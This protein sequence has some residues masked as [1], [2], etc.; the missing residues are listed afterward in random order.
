MSS[1]DNA[2]KIAE[3]PIHIM[4]RPGAGTHPD[5]RTNQAVDLIL[6]NPTLS[7]PQAMLAVGFSREESADRAKQMWIR[8]R[9][10]SKKFRIAVKANSAELQLRPTAAAALQ[11]KPSA[12]MAASSLQQQ[13]TNDEELMGT[14]NAGG[15][16]FECKL[17][18][19]LSINRNI[20][21]GEGAKRMDMRKM[22]L[23]QCVQILSSLA[24]KIICGC[25]GSSGCGVG[26]MPFIH[27]DFITIDNVI[28]CEPTT[29][30]TSPD[31]RE[32]YLS[33]YFI[34]CSLDRQCL[35]KSNENEAMYAFARIAFALCTMGDEPE[36]PDHSLNS[37]TADGTDEELVLN[38]NMRKE[39]SE[40]SYVQYIS[41]MMCEAGVP[42]PM[43]QFISDL[44]NGSFNHFEEVHSHLNQMIEHPDRFLFGETFDV[45]G[46]R[47]DPVVTEREVGD[48]SNAYSCIV[49]PSLP[50]GHPDP[51]TKQ[52]VA[53]MLKNPKQTVPQAM[54]AAGF[55]EEESLDRTKQMW[56]RRRIPAKKFMKEGQTKSTPTT[57]ASAP[58]PAALQMKPSPAAALQMKV[59]PE[60]ASTDEV[61]LCGG[62]AGE[63]PFECKLQ[64]W[65]SIN[66]NNFSGTPGQEGA[67]PMD[68]SKRKIYLEQCVQILHS[69][70][71]R[72]VGGYSGSGDSGGVPGDNVMPFVHPDCIIID[73]VM[74]C[75]PTTLTNPDDCDLYLSA[76]FI[77]CG[78]DRQ[79][80][81]E[82][83]EDKQQRMEAAMYAFARIAFSLCMMGDGPE[84]P[85]YCLSNSTTESG[86][87]MAV[88]LK[89]HG[90]EA[91][92]TDEE[93]EILDTLLKKY[94]MTEDEKCDRLSSAMCDAGIPSPLRRFIYDLMGEERRSLL[95]ADNFLSFNEICTD[96]K[97][98]ID[99]PDDFLHGSSSNVG[100]ITFRDKLY[101]KDA[102]LEVLFDIAYRV[103]KYEDNKILGEHN[104]WMRRKTEVIMISGDPGAGKSQLAKFAGTCLKKRGWCFL[105]CKFDRGGQQ[106]PLSVFSHAFDEYF[107]CYACCCKHGMNACSD[108]STLRAF[109]DCSCPG[110]SQNVRNRI[111]SLISSE[112]LGILAMH[113]PSFSRAM[114]V[115]IPLVTPDKN[116]T[117]MAEL[118]GTLLQAISSKDSPI[119]FL[120]DD[121]Q[122]ADP[123]SLSVLT[124]LIEGTYSE[125]ALIRPNDWNESVP[126]EIDEDSNRIVFLATHR[127]IAAHESAQLA[128]I[129]RKFQIDNLI[130]VTNISLSGLKLESLNEILSDALCMPVR[131]LR[132]LSKLVLQKTDGLPLYV[133]EFIRVLEAEKILNFSYTRGWEWDEDSV[134]IF[135]ITESVAELFAFKLRKLP[136][137]ILLGVQIVG[138]FGRQ[139]DQRL[140]SLVK[141]YDGENSVDINAAIHVA[142][143]EGL[144]ERAGNIF[145]FAHDLILKATVDS[146]SEDDLVPLLRKL[147]YAL[148]EKATGTASLDSVLF[149]VV[150]LIH[151][152]G[153]EVIHCQME[154]AMF[155]KLNLLAALKI[156]TVPD[157]DG[158]MKYAENGIAF[159]S[160][161]CWE[162]QYDLSRQLYEISVMSHFSHYN[163]NH[164]GKLLNRIHTVFEHARDFSD[165]FNTHHIWIKLLSLTNLPRAIEESLLALEQLGVS[166]DLSNIDYTQVCEELV[167]VSSGELDFSL[168]KSLNDRKKTNAMKV[169]TSLILFYTQSKSFL[170]ALISCRMVE[171]TMNDGFC[172]DSIFGAAA[173]ASSLVTSAGDID[174]GHSWGRKAVALMNMSGKQSH[175]PATN[176]ALYGTVFMWKEPTQASLEFLSQGI[177]ASFAYG[178]VE[179]AILNVVVYTARSFFVG[180]QISVLTA[181]VGSFARLFRNRFG[182]QVSS[183]QGYLQSVHNILHK[184]QDDGVKNEQLGPSFDLHL[185]FELLELTKKHNRL[186]L[187]HA[188]LTHLTITMFMVRNLECALAFTDMY[189]EH[190]DA[191]K[192]QMK[193]IFVTNVFYDGLINL[194]FMGKTGDS[195]HLERGNNAVSK[196]RE[197]SRH[198]EWNFKNKLLLLNAELHRVMN[199]SYQAAICYEESIKAANDHKFIN[200]EAIANELAGIFYVGQGDRQRSL[201]HFKRSVEC[202]QKWGAPVIARRIE[203]I[204]E[205]TF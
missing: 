185:D 98:M 59:S 84:L 71:D 93:N 150:D 178:N 201:S 111:K 5:P 127:N 194:Y 204:I 89:L 148:V 167:K 82:S 177:R 77:R 118:F 135:P 81:H 46:K 161:T 202:Y 96:L 73:N 16:L 80:S 79:C 14:S 152:V 144:V 72:I 155:A 113:I 176:L 88:A 8:R 190:F 156:I 50:G 47:S 92:G 36:L 165:K 69:L 7:V 143:N 101:G 102:D 35:R 106:E 173:F 169:M 90:G 133:I 74:V 103:E 68:L 115:A 58:A 13:A 149:L 29:T 170:G 134:D 151:R 179:F 64:T 154:R 25:S 53:R 26:D 9:T 162:T 199:E 34:R 51:R 44:V 163:R 17:Q 116:G 45:L 141:N 6:K 123:L 75:G 129:L 193:L 198:S 18:A 104:R 186:L 182:D 187:F 105:Q 108:R 196:M 24:D 122:W 131:R 21:S 99:N 28:V 112:G 37:I 54:L 203:A 136:Q 20:F 130:E 39:N 205:T 140:L 52:A 184:L 22:Y 67:K 124:L 110:S 146:I 174:C 3:K 159:L 181:E 142:L 119:L 65:I 117:M 168:V 40:K 128:Q 55:S 153:S 66:R 139:V 38:E 91:S 87:K 137:D 2:P 180:K 78:A 189:F 41:T 30:L 195:R 43:R 63:H 172:E 132:S 97:Q 107:K 100:K 11:L 33:A 85:D 57:A 94:R 19:W 61:S 121:L 147:I 157:F 175:I 200:E 49:T 83:K 171:I 27:P 32:H 23:E 188:V 31:D 95:C 197:W 166:F 62:N 158:A 60:A 86:T 42:H 56:I 164:Q 126:I 191:N 138:C 145:S 10:P 76:D 48:P 125:L 15:H 192:S 109:T 4:H 1:N 70:A 160:E 114:D 183:V 12:A 120:I